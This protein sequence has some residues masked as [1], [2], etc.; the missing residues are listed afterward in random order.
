[1]RRNL[2]PADVDRAQGH[3]TVELD[4]ERR[5][6]S[7]DFD[8]QLAVALGREPHRRLRY[9][10]TRARQHHGV[11]DREPGAFV[12]VEGRIALKFD[13]ELAKLL[14]LVGADGEDSPALPVHVEPGIDDFGLRESTLEARE[15]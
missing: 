14:D 15:L 4:C 2:L 1:M 12:A 11:L 13:V 6:R 10:L 8:I 7:L 3:R 5:S 9:L